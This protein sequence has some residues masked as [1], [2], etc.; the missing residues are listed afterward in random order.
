MPHVLVAGHI[1]EAGVALLREARD[2]TFDLVD[3]VSTQSY[4]P[5][6]A[7]ADAVLIRTQ[8]MPASVIERA[9]RLKLVSRHGVGYDAVDVAALNRRGIPLTIVGDVNS[10]AVAEHTL[11]LILA[12]AK[13]TLAYDRAT[14]QS[15]W[16]YRNKL[17]AFELA[18]RTLLV[19]G[20][21]RIGRK[22]ARLA[23]AFDMKVMV[24]DPFVPVEA[25]RQ[26]GLTPVT[27][28]I[29]SLGL[30]DVVTVHAPL[31]P[32]GAVIGS[33]ELAA[34]RPTA[35]V[36]NTARGG[37]VEECALAAALAEG[38]LGGAG[39]D[40][41]ASEPPPGDHPLFGHER[42]VLS[43]HMASLTQECAARMAVDAAQ[44]VLDFFAGRL[45]GALVVNAEHISPAARQQLRVQ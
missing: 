18:N 4:A 1:H 2:V 3:E 19:L 11:M 29:S 28:L 34:M 21:G 36:V 17:E 27:D 32:A 20:F 43:P 10:T 42:V 31:S 44:N 22:V 33:R 15:D 35:V 30:A 9:E 24:Y 12:L 8:P 5:L 13:R 16:L 45:N 6:V 41:F 7:G 40:V 23:Q 38:R 39:L 26:A 14:R 37:L 25:I